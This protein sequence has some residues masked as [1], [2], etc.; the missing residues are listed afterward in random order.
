MATKIT[1]SIGVE[2]GDIGVFALPYGECSTAAA[3]A[4]KTVTVQGDFVLEK[5][6]MVA[7][8]FT[9]TNTASSPTLNVTPQGGTATGAKSIKR[10]G[11]TAISTSALTSWTAGQVVIF[12]YDGTYWQRTFNDTNTWTANSA[13][14]AGYVASGQGYGD[15]LWQTSDTGAPA[16]RKTFGKYISASGIVLG[17]DLSNNTVGTYGGGNSIVAGTGNI[18]QQNVSMN[19]LFGENNSAIDTSDEGTTE[20]ISKYNFFAGYGNKLNTDTPRAMGGVAIGLNNTIASSKASNPDNAVGSISHLYGSIAIGTGNTAGSGASAG[21]AIGSNNSASGGGAVAIGKNN[22]SSS[23][24]AVSFGQGNTASNTYTTSM[25]H[26][27]TA[28]NEYT[29]AVG[30]GNSATSTYSSAFGCSNTATGVHAIAIGS[31]NDSTGG[32]SVCVGYNNDATNTSAVAVGSSNKCQYS[33]GAVVGYSNTT[34]NSYGYALGYSNTVAGTGAVALGYSNSISSGDYTSAIGYSH[35]VTGANNFVGG[36]DHTVY[37]SNNVVLGASHLLGYSTSYE[38]HYC[39]L[40]G[41][42]HKYNSSNATTT[43]EG[44]GR[45]AYITVVGRFADFNKARAQNAT[46]DAVPTPSNTAGSGGPYLFVV[47]NGTSTSNYSTAMVV[48]VSGNVAIKGSLYENSGDYA[49]CFEWSDGNPEWEDRRG[50]FVTFDHD[51]TIR[52]ANEDDDYVL[53]IVS[54]NPCI[55]G[56]SQYEDWKGR[57]KR[58]IYGQIQ[59]EDYEIPAEYNEETGEMISPATI[60]P[61][62]IDAEDYDPEKE[63]VPRLERSEWTIIGMLGKLV[64]DDDGTCEVNGYAKPGKDGIATKGTRENGYR[65]VERIDENH[66]KVL[67]K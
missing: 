61:K 38:A 14:A 13:T 46:S 23:T 63:Y 54:A 44:T 17:T 67:F 20:G 32:Y 28:S 50:R 41:R 26:S 6:S 43:T 57:Y 47:G 10:Y 31:T 59:Y 65:V 25:G 64:L 58:D 66:I 30:Q 11:T 24:T 56:D 39:T 36:Y 2:S 49:E 15:S 9:Y 52:F 37:G 42:G 8:K 1:N 27:N 55:V 45:P 29:T 51:E 60:V 19:Y 62:P 48:G 35:S 53:G 7:V 16:W 40:L 21:Y 12:I 3:T 34:N 5:G 18:V 22:T 33:Y 4:A